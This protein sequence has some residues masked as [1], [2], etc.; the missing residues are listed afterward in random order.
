MKKIFLLLFIVLSVTSCCSAFGG[1]AVQDT[2]YSFTLND[3]SGNPVNLDSYRGKQSLLLSFFTT[4][5]PACQ[6]EM[7]LLQLINE[8]YASK[9]LVIIG[10][11]IKETR[12]NLTAFVRANKLTFKVLQDEKAKVA[13]DFK[14][15]R[16]PAIFIFDK[17]GKLRFKTLYISM[18][19]LEK[20]IQKVLQ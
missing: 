9:G 5:C 2:K 15:S 11:G 13:V 16:I 17:T 10:I 7:P 6:D 14:V 18:E 19:D 1:A 8:K 20:E 12:E 4:W 3:I